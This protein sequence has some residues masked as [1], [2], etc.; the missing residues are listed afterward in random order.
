M[1][2]VVPFEYK[3]ADVVDAKIVKLER[4]KNNFDY[5]NYIKRAFIWKE[6]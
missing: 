2:I 4:S 3:S 5:Y 1:E 6:E